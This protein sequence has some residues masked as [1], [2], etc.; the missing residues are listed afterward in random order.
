MSLPFLNDVPNLLYPSTKTR[1]LLWTRQ[2]EEEDSEAYV[3]NFG[4][5][6][7]VVVAFPPDG[8]LVLL[9]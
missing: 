8:A 5:L 6:P 9:L 7:S 3:T 2:E 1:V 4:Y